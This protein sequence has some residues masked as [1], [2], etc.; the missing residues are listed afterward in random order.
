MS[1]RFSAWPILIA[2]GIGLL[3]MARLTMPQQPASAQCG[4]T[5]SSC[6]TCHETQAKYP[7]KTKGEWHV[8]HAFGDFCVYCHAGDVRAK[9][10][11]KAHAN[12]VEPLADVTYTCATCHTDDCNVRADKYA[13]V[14]G[15]TAGTG[16]GGPMA[17]RGLAPLVPFVPRLAGVGDVPSP[18]GGVSPFAQSGGGGDVSE[19]PTVNWGNVILA[20]M[21]FAL[22]FGGGG[23]VA[24]NERKLATAA[25]S[26]GWDS[27]IQ[28]RPELNEVVSLLARADAE[29][30]KTITQT[31]TE[32]SK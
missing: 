15:V 18:F 12:R 28:S 8:Q 31:L 14:L 19:E 9:D 2:L 10:K 5:A 11:A 22:L 24:W 7:V 6:K 16:S 4:V 20:A 21:A 17:P 32:R 29:T 26:V 25:Q 27:L 3:L 13:S 1:R 30:V 23:F